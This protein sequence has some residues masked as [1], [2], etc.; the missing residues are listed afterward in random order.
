MPSKVTQPVVNV[1]DVSSD[2]HVHLVHEVPH[3]GT[4]QD[5]GW[6]KIDAPK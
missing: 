5:L 4:Q 1:V 2:G 6:F 3:V